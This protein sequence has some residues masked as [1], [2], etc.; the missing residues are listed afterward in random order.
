MYTHL[1]NECIFPFD[2]IHIIQ[3]FSSV[4]SWDISTEYIIYIIYFITTIKV[5]N[6]ILK[7][8]HTLINMVDFTVGVKHETHFSGILQSTYL[9]K[10]LSISTTTKCTSIILL[11]IKTCILP[12]SRYNKTWLL[13]PC[14]RDK[15][16]VIQEIMSAQISRDPGKIMID[17]FFHQYWVTEITTKWWLSII[18][19]Q[20]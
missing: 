11:K 20:I 8:K 19:P 17:N 14:C 6:Q 15:V 7:S 1:S 10:I 2:R 9:Y 12:W 3:D 13:L 5:V 18:I 16:V 4:P